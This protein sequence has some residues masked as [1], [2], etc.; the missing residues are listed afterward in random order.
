MGFHCP[1]LGAPYPAVRPIPLYHGTGGTV[2]GIPLSLL[3]DSISHCTMGQVG[4]SMGFHCPCLGAPYPTVRPI[5]LYHGTGGTVYGIPLSH[6]RTPYPI[7]LSGPHY[8]L[9]LSHSIPKYIM[10]AHLV[11][12]FRWKRC[13]ACISRINL[14]VRKI[15]LV[16]T[17]RLNF[18]KNWLDASNIKLNCL[19]NWLSQKVDSMQNYRIHC[20][21]QLTWFVPRFTCC[22][23]FRLIHPLITGSIS[24]ESILQQLSQSS[25]NQVGSLTQ[26]MHS[27]PHPICQAGLQTHLLHPSSQASTSNSKAGRQNLKEPDKVKE[28]GNHGWHK[29]CFAE[30]SS[31]CG[32]VDVGGFG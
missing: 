25:S 10:A 6:V 5:P 11:Q 29:A 30:V 19:Q 3:R 2:D 9:F 23:Y 28:H 8:V 31:G 4:L 18:C 17:P 27:Y 13:V 21:K 32:Q 26:T 20:G 22:N 24:F 12:N 16:K 15:G 1:C 14:V 7:V